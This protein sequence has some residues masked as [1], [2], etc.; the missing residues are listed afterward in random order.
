[1]WGCS[2]DLELP[3][4]AATQQELRPPRMIG[5]GHNDDRCFWR[6]EVTSFDC[7]REVDADCSISPWELWVPA[8][9][10][11][12]FN[13]HIVRQIRVVA[14]SPGEAAGL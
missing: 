6:R 14:E 4:E 2:N 7:D 3:V 12:D 8:K 10:L 11:T 5:R 1:M 9:E 13:C